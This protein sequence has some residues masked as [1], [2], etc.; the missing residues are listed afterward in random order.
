MYLQLYGIVNVQIEIYPSIP[1]DYVGAVVEGLSMGL[2][3]GNFKQVG[4]FSGGVDGDNYE[5]ILIF[6]GGDNAQTV[7]YSTKNIQDV[8]DKVNAKN[9]SPPAI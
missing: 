5:A 9:T 4:S 8:I 3:D 6:Q 7:E 2:L 1:S